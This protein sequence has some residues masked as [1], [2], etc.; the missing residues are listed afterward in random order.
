[1]KSNDSLASAA[2]NGSASEM[3][4]T[5]QAAQ[6]SDH[7]PRATPDGPQP[8]IVVQRLTKVYHLGQTRVPALRGVTLEVLRGEFVAIQ[9]P[10]GSGKSTF[11]NL[12]GCLDRPSGG[13]YWLNGMEV[14]RLSADKIA[15]VRNRR[16][17]FVFQGFNLLGRATALANVA[18]PLL[19]AGVAR[20]ERER[21]AKRALQIVGLQAR[22]HHHPLQLSG[23]QQQRVA[24]AR[25]LVNSPALLLADEPTGNL[26]SRTAVEIMAVL[27]HLNAMGLTIV[28]VTH[29]PDIA[30]YTQRQIAFRDGQVL[31]DESARTPRSAVED[32]LR[33]R[34]EKVSAAPND[35][36]RIREEPQ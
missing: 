32:L 15:E 17:G 35:T 8:V 29:E 13:E 6:D 34:G 12:L 26:D 36:V 18:L 4:G 28:L 1:M 5:S 33:L 11:M 3:P 16:I 27:Q 31:R 7:T 2:Y 21:R 30:V 14:S 9:G 20:E 10:S 22:M 24:I 25:A 19:Y 23:G